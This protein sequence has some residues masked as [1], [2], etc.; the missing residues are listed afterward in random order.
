M[1]DERS[2]G[3]VAERTRTAFER[4]ARLVPGDP[5][6]NPPATDAQLG[7][8]E[9]HLGRPLPADV[10]TVYRLADGQVQWRHD[11]PR[12]AAGL[13][14]GEPLLPLAGVLLHWDQWAGFDGETGLDEFASSTPEGF[15]H[16]RYALRGWV[17]LTHDGGGNHVGVDL[18]PDV[19]GT[20]GQ[21]ITFGRDDE[22][23]QVLAP[24]LLSYLQQFGDLLE[25]G[26]GVPG[27][28]DEPW[29]LRVPPRTS[30]H[31]LFRPEG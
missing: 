28:D 24:S 6:L 31:S 22:Q 9:A 16:P 14:G 20:V 26:Y 19:R 23:H 4:V 25:Q 13:V 17:P 29:S 11:D 1:T 21:V 10:R 18:D 8:A 5:L 3:D 12:W 27:E 15:V 7:A 2:T 30:P